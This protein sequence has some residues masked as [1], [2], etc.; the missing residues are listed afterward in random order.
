MDSFKMR[1]NG[2]HAPS[3][4]LFEYAM[5]RLNQILLKFDTHFLTCFFSLFRQENT[6]YSFKGEK[7]GMNYKCINV[8]VKLKI[9][10]YNTIDNMHSRSAINHTT[11]QK[12]ERPRR[13]KEP[14]PP[15][16]KPTVKMMQQCVSITKC[17]SHRAISRLEITRCVGVGACTCAS[18]KVM[19]MVC[20]V[21]T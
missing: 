15:R 6:V 19:K 3:G 1:W 12:S 21:M 8:N 17:S 18:E 13:R 4:M 2:Q 11:K 9:T 7:E 16:S 10:M 14:P 5:D 20:G